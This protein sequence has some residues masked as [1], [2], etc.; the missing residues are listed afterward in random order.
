MIALRKNLM[1]HVTMASKNLIFAGSALAAVMLAAV[2][3][4]Y[5]RGSWACNDGAWMKLGHPLSRQPKTFC[6]R[7]PVPPVPPKVCSPPWSCGMLSRYEAGMKPNVWYL[8]YQDVTGPAKLEI[9]F[10]KGAKCR[11]DGM[12]VDCAVLNPPAGS[13]STFT[14]TKDGDVFRV[15]SLDFFTKV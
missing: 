1:S 2:G 12:T 11:Q 6:A 9:V 15:S 14:G 5:F 8:K 13:A 10:I 4:T 7:K 3:L